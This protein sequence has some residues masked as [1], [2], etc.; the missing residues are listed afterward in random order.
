MGVAWEGGGV[1][2]QYREVRARSLSADCRARARDRWAI[3]IEGVSARS[4]G[5]GVRAAPVR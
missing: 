2:G 3:G 4:V 1:E 5:E